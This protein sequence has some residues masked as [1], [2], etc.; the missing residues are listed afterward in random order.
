MKNTILLAVAVATV[1]TCFAQEAKVDLEAQ[2]RITNVLEMRLNVRN[3]Q[4]RTL[5][6]DIL[7]LHKE[8]DESVNQMVDRVATLKD[9]VGSAKRVGNLKIEMIQGLEESIETFRGKRMALSQKLQE[10]NSSISKETI[11]GEITHFD[12][13]MEMHLDQMLKLSKSFTQ[14]EDVKKYASYSGDGG[15]WYGDAIEI[16]D[17]WQQNRRDWYSNK[18]QRKI[19]NAALEK[20]IDRCNL[21]IRGLQANLEEKNLSE[22]DRK[23]IQSEL[24]THLS[25]LAM[26]QSEVKELL[27][28]AKPDTTEVTRDEAKVLEEA[29][30]ELMDDIQRD[31]R[32]IAYKHAQLN[33]E[34]EKA[35]RLENTLEA[36]KKWFA[37]YEKKKGG[38]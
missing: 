15:G 4:I 17:E 29:V 1:G 31:V 27:V 19:V 25:M 2:K 16:S 14:S 34:Q 20:S 22:I 33:A 9:S 18:N 8:M 37:D 21:R 38:Q 36:R 28:V 5:R 12:E 11:K 30:G 23:L 24:D 26:R 3:T 10:G 13:H 7:K 35:A 32:T 6:D